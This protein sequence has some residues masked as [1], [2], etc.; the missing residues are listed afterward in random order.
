MLYL[1][2]MMYMGQHNGARLLNGSFEAWDYGPVQPSIYSQVKMYGRDPIRG[3]FFGVGS[4]PVSDR[5]KM[6]DDAY[7]QLSKM[8]AAKL[9]DI[10]HW[11]EGAWAKYY[12]PGVRGIVIPDTEILDEY[13][14]RTA[15]TFAASTPSEP[16]TQPDQCPP[17]L[18]G[19]GFYQA[20]R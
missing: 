20:A 10:T 11:K 4:L 12:I 1:A 16:K 15:G 3:G 7:D 6:L 8:T 19:N 13:R 2:Q 5:Q 9:V 17:P 14:K 18:A